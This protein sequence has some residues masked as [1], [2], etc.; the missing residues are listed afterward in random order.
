ML[1]G[2]ALCKLLKMSGDRND[3]IGNGVAEIFSR[4]RSSQGCGTDFFGTW[5]LFVLFSPRLGFAFTSLGNL[6][7]QSLL[8][9][10]HRI[11]EGASR[12]A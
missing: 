8:L 2:L 12:C 9:R 6:V 7:G 4:L 1:G 5:F 11:V 3:G 10:L